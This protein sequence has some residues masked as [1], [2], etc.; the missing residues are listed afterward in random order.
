VNK[1]Y[2]YKQGHDRTPRK[3]GKGRDKKQK[4]KGRRGEGMIRKLCLLS[5]M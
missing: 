1:T 5:F 3:K 2:G 4:E